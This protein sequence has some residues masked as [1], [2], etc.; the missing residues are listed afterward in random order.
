MVE[1]VFPM[2]ADG[3][4]QLEEELETLK[5]EKRPEVIERIKIAR[6]FGDLSENSEYESAKDEQSVLE[7]RIKQI[8]EMLKYAQ[9]VDATQAEADEVAI[10]KKVV[11][12]EVGEDDPEEYIIVGS[13]ESDPLS[14]KISNNSPIANALIGK[15]TG[16]VVSIATPGGEFDVEILEVTLAD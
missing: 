11:F 2:T 16:D 12:T 4:Q 13:S 7:G 5:L 15:K 8:Q 9:V 1:R 14:G 6:S 10:G 3:K